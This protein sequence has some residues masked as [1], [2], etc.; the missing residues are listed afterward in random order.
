MPSHPY[1]EQLGAIIGTPGT[2]AEPIDWAA[3]ESAIGLRLPS[4]YRELHDRYQPYAFAEEFC[5]MPP[6][7]TPPDWSQEYSLAAEAE[8][9]LDDARGLRAQSPET[10]PY[11]LFPEPG[12]IYPWAYSAGND[13]FWWRTAGALDEW[14]TIVQARDQG[15][16]DWW[17]YA[18]SA[19]ELLFK[20]LTGQIRCPVFPHLYEDP[21]P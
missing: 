16:D 20:L 3:V 21:A 13:V 12:G 8:Q 6:P 15:E 1:V 10:C 17:E 5:W 14:P 19:S 11:P 2:S 7:V 4:D 18:C 9:Y